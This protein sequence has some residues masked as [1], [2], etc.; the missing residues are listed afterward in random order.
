MT[1]EEIKSVTRRSAGLPY[2]FA[3]ILRAEAIIL[4]RRRSGATVL[5]D[6]TMA[7]LLR[8]AKGEYENVIC[9]EGAVVHALNVLRM[10]YRD[11]ALRFSVIPYLTDALILS[12]EG[13]TS[14]RS[15]SAYNPFTNLS[16]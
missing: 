11:S 9:S 1:N 2:S 6:K 16:D 14:P 7:L 15:V 10:L 8:V 13:Y 3:G 5:L 12:I 4:Q